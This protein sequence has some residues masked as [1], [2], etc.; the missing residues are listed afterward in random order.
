MNLGNNR[1]FEMKNKIFSKIFKGISEPITIQ[2]DIKVNK[3]V[4]H[5]HVS[6]NFLQHTYVQ[7]CRLKNNWDSN[8]DETVTSEAQDEST[9]L[10]NSTDS[11]EKLNKLP[12]E[13]SE[14]IPTYSH[15]THEE[16]IL[17]NRTSIVELSDKKLK[18]VNK[19]KKKKSTM[20][21]WFQKKFKSFTKIFSSKR[22]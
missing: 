17:F 18:T 8:R 16:T 3:S 6:D 15:V 2:N 14:L 12:D 13:I 9:K 21:G 4:L 1:S 5:N 20:F 7:K 11:E 22:N 19:S 10:S